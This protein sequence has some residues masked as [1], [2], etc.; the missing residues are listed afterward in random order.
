MLWVNQE[1]STKRDACVIQKYPI[2]ARDFFSEISEQG[3]FNPTDS[4]L[5][6]IEVCPSKMREMRIDR[7]SHN[8]GVQLS[9][10]FD[11]VREGD[12]LRR[13][14]K[15]EVQRIEEENLKEAMKSGCATKYRAYQILS[16]EVGE[17]DFLKVIVDNRS[18]SKIWGWLLNL[19]GK[20]ARRSYKNT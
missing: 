20:Q 10:F 12:D 2:V 1:Q 18:A 7:N 11:P 9:E 13:T 15:S 16:L 17:L 3:I 6:A 19:S 8:F 14:N 5:F 4:A